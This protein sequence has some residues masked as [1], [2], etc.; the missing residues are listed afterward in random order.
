MKKFLLVAGI[1][2]LALFVI[3]KTFLKDKGVVNKVLPAEKYERLENPEEIAVGIEPGNKAPDFT[4]TDL[5][6]KTVSL[7]DYKGKR[8]FLNFWA[9][10][11]PPC[12]AEM[13]D[14]QELYEEKAI[15]DFEIL[16][17]NMT[18]IEKNKGDEMDFVKDHGLTF[19]IPLDVKGQV[20]GEY[21]IM[22]YPTSFFIDSDGIIRSRV[23]GA[24]D[25]DFIEKESKR[26]P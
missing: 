17:V 20:M 10:W 14:M 6:G 5:E 22:A 7:S 26:L 3:D 15:G 25:K 8:V 2:L 12:K 19:P 21:E 11:C 1:I 23:M 16:A 24:V 13:P 18:F 9:S 4:L